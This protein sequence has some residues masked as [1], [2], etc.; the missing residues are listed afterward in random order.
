MG[1]LPRF[2]PRRLQKLNELTLHNDGQYSS[3]FVIC[4]LGYHLSAV[5]VEDLFVRGSV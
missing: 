4:N 2:M 1:R 5:Q 3:V